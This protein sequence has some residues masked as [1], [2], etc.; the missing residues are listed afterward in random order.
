M[1]VQ[2]GPSVLGL[3]LFGFLGF[4]GALPHNDSIQRMRA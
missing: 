2:G 1:D 4:V 3:P